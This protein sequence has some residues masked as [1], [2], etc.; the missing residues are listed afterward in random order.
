M[1]RSEECFWQLVLS[2]AWAL[3]TELR[4]LGFAAST[5]NLSIPPN[6]KVMIIFLICTLPEIQSFHKNYIHMWINSR[7]FYLTT[8]I[9]NTSLYNFKEFLYRF[10]IGLDLN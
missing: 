8:D 7:L 6:L 4:L 3:V 1:L 2:T 5:L 10:T 9:T